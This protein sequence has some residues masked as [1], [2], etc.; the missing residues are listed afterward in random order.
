VTDN[1]NISDPSENNDVIIRVLNQL[2]SRQAIVVIWDKDIRADLRLYERA[3]GG[4]EFIGRMLANVGRNGVG[5]TKEGD[6]KSPAGIFSL[7]SAF[8]NAPAPEGC[9]YPYRMLTEEDYW[10]DDSRSKY[11]NQWVKFKDGDW[12]DWESAECLWREKVCYK[13][14]VIINYNLARQEG[15]GSAIFLHVWAGENSPTQ[16]CTA[17][18]EEDMIRILR[19]LEF[20]KKPVIVQGTYEDVVGIIKEQ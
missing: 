15:K 14:A 17:V 20:D 8:G 5:K 3:N 11:Y 18:S 4:W 1:L 12:K 13:Y 2:Q 19:W 10:V 7:G 6:Q 16:G 9:R